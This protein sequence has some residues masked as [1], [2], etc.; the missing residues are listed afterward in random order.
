MIN[1]KCPKCNNN[2]PIKDPKIGQKVICQSCNS[3]LKTIWLL[4]IELDFWDEMIELNKH[5][6]E[7]DVPN[8]RNKA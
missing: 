6:L 2:I 3:I 5:T 8:R 4:P 1:A 7:S